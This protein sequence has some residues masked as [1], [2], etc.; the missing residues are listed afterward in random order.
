MFDLFRSRDKLVRIML[1]AI[2]IVV[3]ASMV[4]YLIPNSGLNATTGTDDTVLADVAGQKLTQRE[5]QQRFAS[6]MQSMQGVTPE[7]AQLFF[8]Q[9]L[10]GQIQGMAVDYEARKMGIT[11]S[12]D[13]VLAG[14]MVEYRPFFPGGVVN[15]DQFEQYLASQG[16]TVEDA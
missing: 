11:A 9:F 15:R 1:G 2:L 10:D 4:T 13:E 6:Q 16:L 12:D 7:M 3:A 8:P 5:F 14:M